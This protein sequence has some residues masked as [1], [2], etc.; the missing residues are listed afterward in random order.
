MTY[1]HLGS[2]KMNITE[3]N[4]HS[5]CFKCISWSAVFAGGLVGIGLTFLLNL[6]SVAIGATVFATSKEGIVTIV[7]GGFLGMLVGV[8]AALFVSGWV[9]GYLGRKYCANR[10][11]G[12]LYGFLAWCVTLL[13]TVTLAS[14]MNQF[15]ASY[16]AALSNSSSTIIRTTSNEAAPVVKERTHVNTRNESQSTV[17]VNAEKAADA[18][19]ISLFITF[20]LFLLGA[21]ASCYGGFY[22][23]K[24]ENEE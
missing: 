12:A 10:H 17:T 20:F 22:G 3:R 18:L 5:C 21:I 1:A 16:Y 24:Q 13:I 23:F 4:E 6:F 8:I 19:S 9:S 2:E 15:V 14:N 7:V 11:I